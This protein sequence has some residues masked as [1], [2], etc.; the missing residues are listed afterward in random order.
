MTYEQWV[1]EHNSDSQLLRECWE[2]AQT[3]IKEKLAAKL[4]DDNGYA[5]RKFYPHLA[6]VIKEVT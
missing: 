4:G 2:A 5:G 1:V 6:D 3:D